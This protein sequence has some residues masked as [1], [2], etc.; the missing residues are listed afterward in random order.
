MK[1]SE[2]NVR[3]MPFAC[4]T[5]RAINSRTYLPPIEPELGRPGFRLGQQLR[6]DAKGEYLCHTLTYTI[7]DSATCQ[8]APLRRDGP[9][10]R[11]KR[12]GDQE[13]NLRLV[14]CP[15]DLYARPPKLAG[16][17]AGKSFPR[18]WP[19]QVGTNRPFTGPDSSNLTT[20]ECLQIPE[21]DQI[22]AGNSSACDKRA[23]RNLLFRR[24][25]ETAS[26]KFRQ[27]RNSI[28]WFPNLPIRE[29]H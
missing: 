8:A 26:C 11:G 5:S 7:S 2:A 17:G 29:D 4:A 22:C 28:K 20:K 6:W 12:D 25:V 27:R 13:F 19:V 21:W 3:R 16:S 14:R 18:G 10:L 24:S 1:S 15:G 23:S 9:S